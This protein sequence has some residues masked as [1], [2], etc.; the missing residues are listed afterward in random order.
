NHMAFFTLDSNDV[1]RYNA[2]FDRNLSPYITG[3][4]EYRMTQQWKIG[5]WVTQNFFQTDTLPHAYHI[6][7]LSVSSYA[8][9][10]FFEDKLS[11]TSRFSVLGNYHFLSST[12]E[13]GKENPMLDL[14]VEVEYFPIHN[15]GIYAKGS[16]L[17]NQN[18]QRWQG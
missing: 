17:L 9:G 4:I 15:L 12:G 7:A 11:F 16:N 2:I 13:Q 6:P 14:Q 3:N 10:S 18:F 1:T 8:K 5:G